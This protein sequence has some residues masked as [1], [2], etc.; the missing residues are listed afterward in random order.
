MALVFVA[1]LAQKVQF[2]GQWNVHSFVWKFAPVPLLMH[3]P[4][5]K[6][7]LESDFSVQ[8][9]NAVVR[10]LRN[11]NHD[12]CSFNKES[13]SFTVQQMT[14]NELGHTCAEHVIP[15]T[16]MACVGQSNQPVSYTHLTLP[17][18]SRV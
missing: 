13:Q 8:K 14:L 1:V 10:A 4:K 12:W 2:C 15:L 5:A 18:T 16:K 3:I 7:L 6:M 11:D 17:T 9:S